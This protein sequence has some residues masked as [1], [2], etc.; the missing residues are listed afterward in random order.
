LAAVLDGTGRAE[1]VRIGGMDRQ[2]LRDWGSSPQNEAG[3][4]AA[5]K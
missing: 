3:S 5:D 2:T 1:A 4:A